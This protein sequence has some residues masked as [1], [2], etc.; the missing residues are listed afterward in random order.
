MADVAD[1]FQC[2]NKPKIGPSLEDNPVKI[3]VGLFLKGYI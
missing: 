1:V 2:L 3:C